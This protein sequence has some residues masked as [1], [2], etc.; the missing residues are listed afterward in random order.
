M[1]FTIAQNILDKYNITL[2][3]YLILYISSKEINIDNIKESLIAKGFADKDLFSKNNIVVSDKIKD[4]ISTILIDSDKSVIDKEEEYIQLANELRNIYPTGRKSGTTYLWRGSTAEVAKKLKTLV[5][6]YG[7]KLNKEEVINA[8][9]EY[10]NSFNGDYRYMHLLK[11]FILK[12][13][14][15]ADGNIEVKSELMS[16]IENKDQLK[17]YNENWTSTLR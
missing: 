1:K 17:E 2:E 6:K 10:I 14:R 15:D 9:K 7:Y 5:V 4:I 8:T 3:E 12:S 11:Y 16:I 13:V